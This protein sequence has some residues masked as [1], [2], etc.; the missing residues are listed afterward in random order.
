M[1]LRTAPE[2]VRVRGLCP[3]REP[4]TRSRTDGAANPCK[5]VLLTRVERWN[6]EMFSR[7]VFRVAISE[8]HGHGCTRSSTKLSIIENPPRV[9]FE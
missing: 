3:L 1:E 2:L 7:V 6:R 5:V 4:R 9:L 8:A